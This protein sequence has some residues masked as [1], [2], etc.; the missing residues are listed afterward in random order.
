MKNRASII[1]W[2]M[3]ALIMNTSIA[4]ADD[5]CQTQDDAFKA[6][7]EIMDKSCEGVPE[8]PGLDELTVENEITFVGN[9]AIKAWIKCYNIQGEAT[10]A[11]HEKEMC[12]IRYGSKKFGKTREEAEANLLEVS[13]FIIWK[14]NLALLAL[15]TAKGNNNCVVVKISD[16]IWKVMPWTCQE[17]KKSF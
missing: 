15:E 11:Y 5:V 9:K 1:A 7:H 10:N 2:A 13:S 17:E 14:I 3:A 4:L 16:D 6:I 8:I 12:E